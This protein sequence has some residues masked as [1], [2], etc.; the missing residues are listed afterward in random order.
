MSSD[1]VSTAGHG[2]WDSVHPLD[3]EALAVFAN[4]GKS[5][6]DVRVVKR[7][8]NG[9]GV[10]VRRVMQL[11]RDLTGKPADQLRIL[12]LGCGDGVY[13]I[14]AA[15]KGMDAFGFDGRM[16]RMENGMKAAERLGITNAHFG[17]EDV[18][19]LNKATNG[20]FDVIWNLGILYH[21]DVPDLFKWLEDLYEML[22]EGGVMIIDTHICQRVTDTAEYKG[23]KYEGMRSRE[24]ED[25]ET[26]EQRRNKTF[27]SL[28]NTFNFLFSRDALV[29]LLT[30]TGFTCVMEVHAP[31]EIG[32]RADRVTMVATKG[33]RIRLSVY[34]WV[35]DK[36]ESQIIEVLKPA[37]PS[38][39]PPPKKQGGVKGAVK[40]V[41]RKMGIEIKR[42]R[43]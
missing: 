11:T 4:K 29:H 15:T 27:R 6:P 12:D 35:N 26:E 13:T 21:L 14:E 20:E 42:A 34:P 18:R 5:A 23:Q 17:Q 41:F 30:N 24:H 16:I 37:A 22:R 28:D 31:L 10:K 39:P 38:A 7:D 40:A 32:K 25:N 2:G 33:K 9:N 1:S 36:S 43:K 19:K 8:V 3:A